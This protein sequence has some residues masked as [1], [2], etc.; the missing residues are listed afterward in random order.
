M[1]NNRGQVPPT[2]TPSV[3]APAPLH[4]ARNNNKSYEVY[5]NSS[6]ALHLGGNLYGSDSVNLNVK[7]YSKVIFYTAQT[8]AGSV[9]IDEGEVWFDEFGDFGGGQIYV[10]V[11]DIFDARTAKLFIS[12]SNGGKTVSQNITINDAAGA[13]YRVLGG[14]NSSGVNTYSGSVT[15][16]GD[17]DLYATSG[18]T[19]DF[20]GAISGDNTKLVYIVGGGTVRYSTAQGYEGNTTITDGTLA[21]GSGGDLTSSSVYLG[22]AASSARLL[23]E[24]NAADLD[25]TIHVVGGGGTRTIQ[26]SDNVVLSGSIN[27]SESLTLT[28]DAGTVT[29]SGTVNMNTNGERDL[30]VGGAGNTT[31]SGAI[32]ST[33]GA[34]EINKSGAGTLTLAG[35]NAGELFKVHIYEGAIAL[36]SANALGS[37]Y[38][39]KVNFD[40]SGTLQVNADVG[41]AS[42]GLRVANGV[43]ATI[44]VNA[45]NT[46]TVATLA[47]ISGSGT[48]TKTGD[49]TL[50]LTGNSSGLSGTLNLT[51]GTISGSGS[52]SSLTQTG[53]ILSP[54]NSPGT[55]TL[56]NATWTSGTYL[57][58]INDLN[59]TEGADPGWDFVNV[60][61][62]LT[63]GAGYEL[64]IDD[65][66]ALAGWDSAASYSW[67][68][69]A[70]ADGLT[71]QS[72]NN[73]VLNTS[74][75]NSNPYAGTFSIR[76]EDLGG[77]SGEIWLDYAGAPLDPGSSV[78]EPTTISLALL[79]GLVLYSMGRQNRKKRQTA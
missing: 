38:G 2:P 68:V 56:G 72:V 57:W 76:H 4:S 10:G 30:N 21:I 70:V 73:L 35:D 7:Q 64:A 11:N 59:G 61:G 71:A 33:T 13:Q 9:N 41:P 12:D 65:L 26:T 14:L 5:G 46:F 69:V 22:G 53:G 47:N 67:R 27:L 24:A 28:S 19:V 29:V 37:G 8:F 75:W 63:I 18:G 58:E 16:N 78:P 52:V 31:I 3:V 49:G 77:G 1:G 44:D 17:V 39:D 48:F 23:M 55:L 60:T 54:G 66:G 36:N 32:N 45:G 40:A 34:S 42:L 25:R 6:K 79:S 50:T 15:L 62:G 51:E 20:S 43:T 74:A